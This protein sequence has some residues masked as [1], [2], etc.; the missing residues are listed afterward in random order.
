MAHFIPLS[1]GGK[2][3][4]DLTRIFVREIW[5]LHG[6][7][8]DIISDRDS[9]FSSS[10][11]KVFLATLGIKPRIS[12]AFHPQSDG[13]TERIHQTIEAY[14][15]SSANKERSDWCNLLPMAEYAYNNSATAGT[16]QTPFHAN[17]DRLP[18]IT[19]PLRLGNA[20]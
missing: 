7:L 20:L 10:A 16:G 4:E 9:R 1:A 18:G 13:Q 8:Q 19:T 3:A 14:L 15:R 11:W 5:R 17:Y 6:M 12:T 2:S